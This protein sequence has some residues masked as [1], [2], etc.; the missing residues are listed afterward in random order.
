MTRRA[1]LWAFDNDK[2]RRRATVLATMLVAVCFMSLIGL[3]PFSLLEIKVIST[4]EGDASRQLWYAAAFL[5]TVAVTLG[6]PQRLLA[7]P[8]ALTIALAYCWFSLAWSAVPGIGLRRVGLT[9]MIIFTIFRCV[10][11]L[12]YVRTVALLRIMLPLTIALD[13]FAVAL[14]PSG[15]HRQ[16]DLGGLTHLL[17]PGIVGSWRGVQKHKNFAGAVC[18]FTILLFVFDARQIN[19]TV[20]YVV[21]LATALFL[22]KTNSKTSA[23]LLGIAIAIGFAYMQTQS[24]YGRVLRALA[25]PLLAI[26][27]TIGVGVFAVAGDRI[28]APLS[29][30]EAFTGRMAIW[31]TTVGYFRDHPWTGTGFGSFWNVG[32][33]SP[34]YKYG[35]G[36][37]ARLGNGHSGLFDLLAQIGAPGMALV[38]IALAIAPIGKIL[39]HTPVARGTCAMLLAMLCFCLFHNVTETSMLDRDAIV[40]VF[41]M[42]SLALIGDVVVPPSPQRRA[43]VF[44]RPTGRQPQDAVR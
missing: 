36:W 40:E 9:T 38:L 44:D 42:I 37:V 41:M 27:A 32:L 12:G 5:I 19:R 15:I 6:Q 28:I 31:P 18:A 30:P 33:N 14:F 35:H 29:R 3:H 11:E 16:E 13:F 21:I 4:G 39:T 24:R 10:D 20:R 34:S 1:Q 8:R 7:L 2:A 43:S 22:Y 23:L 26:A 25:L 17:D